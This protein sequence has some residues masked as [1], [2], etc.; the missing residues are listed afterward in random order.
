[1]PFMRMPTLDQWKDGTSVT[2]RVRSAELKAIDTAIQTFNGQPN[3]ANLRR[4]AVALDLWIQAKQR[5]AGE[6]PTG[7][8]WKRNERNTKRL[9]M[10]SLYDFLHP[11]PESFLDDADKAARQAVR[12]HI[13][14]AAGAMFSGASVG[15]KVFGEKQ[16][17]LITGPDKL[18]QANAKLGLG[19]RI[20]DQAVKSGLAVGQGGGVAVGS[21]G[22]A[23]KSAVKA[24]SAVKS[25]VTPQ[26]FA[27]QT[28]AFIFGITH[29]DAAVNAVMDIAGL[30]SVATF[31]ANCAPLLGALGSAA[32]ATKAAYDMVSAVLAQED[33]VSRRAVIRPGDP[34]AALDAL[35]QL[36]DQEISRAGDSLMINA[37]ATVSKLGA[38]LLDGGAI[39]GPAIGA[40]QSLAELLI[41]IGQIAYDYREMTD[42][43]AILQDMT[44]NGK[45]FDVELFRKCPIVACYYLMIAETSTI[46]FFLTSDYGRPGWQLKVEEMKKIADPIWEKAAEFIDKS[47]L[48]VRPLSAHR[49]AFKK[50]I[51]QRVGEEA[52]NVGVK[53]ANLLTAGR[54]YPQTMQAIASS[55]IG[56]PT[57]VTTTNT[58]ATIS[59]AEAQ[60][61][62]GGRG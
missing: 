28:R 56:L 44:K 24:G 43:N 13:A 5:A 2:G 27:A 59:L 16:H 37:A 34:R 10:E 12:D 1:M 29:A 49:L 15:F 4:V 52:S 3:E 47:R 55:G 40:A 23:L 9:F 48:E 45:P 21:A 22:Y 32:K 7:Q 39:S 51:V 60:R 33:L 6:G 26:E 20:K 30:H 25:V 62:F 42:A 54:A 8:G 31:A 50:S 11:R 61:R 17:A 36:M 35:N 58:Q 18:R 14:K 53:M 41:L 57:N 46:L 19:S 38:L